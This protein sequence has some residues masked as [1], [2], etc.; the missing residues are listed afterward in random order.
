MRANEA[1]KSAAEKKRD[2]KMD[3]ISRKEAE[4]PFRGSQVSGAPGLNEVK[5]AP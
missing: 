2:Q 1:A 4:D 5:A 3:R